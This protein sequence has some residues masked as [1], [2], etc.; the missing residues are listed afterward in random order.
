MIFYSLGICIVRIGWPKRFYD[1]IGLNS[2]AFWEKSSF[3]LYSLGF[4]T[5]SS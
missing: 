5:A 4:S 3:M 1:K 2:L